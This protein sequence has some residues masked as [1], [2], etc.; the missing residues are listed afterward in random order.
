MEEDIMTVNIKNFKEISIT[1]MDRLARK[2]LKPLVEIN[3]IS[4][5][6][7]KVRNEYIPFGMKVLLRKNTIET[8]LPLFLDHEDG[9]INILYRGFKEACGYCKKGGPGNRCARH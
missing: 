7:N 4:A 9:L 5:L 1:E 6:C 3:D 2:E 8:E